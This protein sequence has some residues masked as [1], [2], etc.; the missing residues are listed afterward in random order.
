MAHRLHYAQSVSYALEPNVFLPDPPT[1]SISAHRR[2]SL[3]QTPH[4]LQQNPISPRSDTIFTVNILSVNSSSPLTQT[5]TQFPLS[6]FFGHLLSAQ[7]P[8]YRDVYANG[9]TIQLV[10]SVWSLVSSSKLTK[11]TCYCQWIIKPWYMYPIN[12]YLKFDNNP[13]ILSP[14]CLEL[15]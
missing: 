7:T 10:T 2:A 4:F 14:H 15:F 1:Q 12:Y 13:A 3:T 11:M 8:H 9:I 5:Q 6:T